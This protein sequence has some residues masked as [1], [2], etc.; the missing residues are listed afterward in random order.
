MQRTVVDRAPR[1][2]V[3]PAA[4]VGADR[5]RP[6][7]LGDPVAE[8]PGADGRGDGAGP[9]LRRPVGVSVHGTADSR[10]AQRGFAGADL[11][12]GVDRAVD[13][14]TGNDASGRPQL[15]IDALE[16]RV[17]GGVGVEHAGQMAEPRTVEAGARVDVAAQL[18]ADIMER[19]RPQENVDL[20]ITQF[21]VNLNREDKECI[22][23]RYDTG[24]L[25]MFGDFG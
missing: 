25:E 20:Q 21:F 5:A 14:L 15:Q 6:V 17:R 2:D 9:G 24:A 19:Q 22:V 11:Q 1:Q 12:R 23:I 10:I 18:G 4:A 13:T 8:Q 16:R 7:Q 3:Q